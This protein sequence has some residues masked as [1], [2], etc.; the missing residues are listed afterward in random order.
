MTLV[1]FVV[2]TAIVLA[3]AAYAVGQT[4]SRL[5]AAPPSSLF[6]FDE[7]VEFVATALPDELSARLTYGDLRAVVAAHL[8]H[9]GRI[10]EDGDEVVF[11]DDE[12]RRAVAA[13]G[14]VLVRDLTPGDVDAVLDAEVEY[15]EAIGAVGDVADDVA[16]DAAEDADGEVDEA[17]DDDDGDR[18]R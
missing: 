12:V 4:A 14:D 15:L 3:I 10:E 2:V 9:L 18:D 1:V 11:V 16:E 5:A 17:P 8:D 6:E 13:R 7:A